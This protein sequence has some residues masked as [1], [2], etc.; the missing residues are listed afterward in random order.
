MQAIIISALD[1]W[2][3]T[4]LT[5]ITTSSDTTVLRSSDTTNTSSTTPY[6]PF[7]ELIELSLN[8]QVAITP[9]N[10]VDVVEKSNSLVV[11]YYP[12]ESEVK[13][14]I[15]KPGA[16]KFLQ[17]NTLLI[18]PKSHDFTDYFEGI[19]LKIGLNTK[20]FFLDDSRQ[21]SHILG[22]GTQKIQI[23]VRYLVLCKYIC[24]KMIFKLESWSTESSQFSRNH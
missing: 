8:N 18:I 20:I 14:L 7:E 11:F 23:K 16:Q 1:M 2:P 3:A 21:L 6:R 12:L 17:S 24:T 4:S 19:K 9:W 13:N 22:T 5:A 10:C 15:E